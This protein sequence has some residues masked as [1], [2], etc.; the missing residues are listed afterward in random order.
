[1]AGL[2]QWSRLLS[3][4]GGQLGLWLGFS[5]LTA[6]ELLGLLADI[7]RNTVLK[8]FGRKR[9]SKVTVVSS[10]NDLRY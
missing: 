6:V 7:A 3:D 4:L 9:V 5:L 10:R 2:P 8:A 1:M